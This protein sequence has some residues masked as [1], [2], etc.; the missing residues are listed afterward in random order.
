MIAVELTTARL[1][2]DQPTADDRELI[3]E[4]CRD[5]I[6]ERFMLTPWPYEPAHVD[7]FVRDH[8]PNAWRA[9]TEYTWALRDGGALLGM[10][11][12]REASRMIG[13]WLGAPHRGKGYMPEA[14][15]AVADWLFAQG[16]ERIEWEAVVGNLASAAVAR[17]VGF[18]FA[19]TGPSVL[20]SREGGTAA[21]W[22]GSLHRDD[23]RRQK[24]GW[25]A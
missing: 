18:T 3:V 6:F 14:V 24:D 5:P 21:C 22:H 25:P 15:S 4:Y 20:G 9:D 8:V 12:Y 13:F 11:S 16:R 1:R 19:G 10:V 23:D 7:G 2:L 17:K